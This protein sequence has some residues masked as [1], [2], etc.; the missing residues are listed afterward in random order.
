MDTN[1]FRPD[2]AILGAICFICASGISLSAA[3]GH[4][5][6]QVLVTTLATASGALIA[7]IFP[8]TDPGGRSGTDERKGPS[9]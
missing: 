2:T 9:V 8:R 1:S 5:P 7:L 4:E 6:P 3:F